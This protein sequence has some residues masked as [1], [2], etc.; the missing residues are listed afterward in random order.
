MAALL[1]G[2]WAEARAAAAGL[3][4]AETCALCH[5]GGTGAAVPALCP[6]C[7]LTLPRLEEPRCAVCG[8]WF[9]GNIGAP[10][11][12]TN[13]A[14]RTFAFE[15]ATAPFQARGCLRELIH[16]FKYERQ[17]W[18]GAS[19]G[20]LLAGALVG[21]WADPRLAGGDWLLVP[22]PLHPRRLRE[23]EFNQALELAQA[24]ARLTGHPVVDVL[25]RTRYTTVQASLAR[26]DRLDNLRGAFRLRRGWPWL[27]GGRG[28]RGVVAGRSVLLIDDVFTTGATMDACARVLSREGR[29]RRVV[30][31]TL[32]RG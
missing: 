10:F 27:R 25:R 24:A 9:V 7:A 21:P 3:V 19:L 1:H 2:L 23:R 4:F 30:A 28:G 31:L 8:E 5:A 26:H 12:C 20:R 15:F 11:R 13:C 22:V 32:A 29:A 14:D 16:R 18:L 17:L 6:S